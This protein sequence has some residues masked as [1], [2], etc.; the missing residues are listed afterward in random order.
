MG[1][2]INKGEKGLFLRLT[3]VLLMGVISAQILIYVETLQ[4]KKEYFKHDYELAGYLMDKHPEIALDIPAVFTTYKTENQ[5]RMGKGILETSGY[6]ESTEWSLF[7]MIKH[8]YRVKMLRVLVFSFILSSAVL[9]IVFRYHNLQYE[10]IDRYT[11]Q[12]A[13]I[14]NK[15]VLTRLEANEEGSLGRL[16]AT[17][18]QLITSLN[19]HIQKEKNSKV[20]LKETLTNISHQLKTPLSA[21]TMYTEIMQ[22]EITD[23]EVIANF[24]GKSGNELTRMQQLISNLLKMARLDAGIIE[25]NKNTYL[26]NDIILQV[27]EGFEPR[28]IKEQKTFLVRAEENISYLCDKEWILEALSNIVKNAIE[29]TNPGDSIEIHLEETQLMVEISVRD[30]GVG[31]H[32]D[33]INHIFKRFYRS[34]FSQNKQG[35]GIG[36]NLAKS[37]IEMHNGFISVE[38]SIKGTA[39]KIHLPKLTK[40]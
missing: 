35:T 19:T 37:I 28:I 17:T 26:L 9:I 38:S 1:I 33:D 13:S 14:M 8:L 32:P 27:M 36:L 24:M 4:I 10:K 3:L 11:E 21:L 6:K 20:F 40:L 22:D 31:I 29:H 34:K 5:L 30:N 16:A 25:L 2:L 18:N 23:N 7:P 39:F 15:E 12:V